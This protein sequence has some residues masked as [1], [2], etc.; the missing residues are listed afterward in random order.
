VATYY[1]PVP[2]NFPALRINLTGEGGSDQT[3]ICFREGSTG[4]FD[5][6]FDAHKLFGQ[7]GVP[8]VYSFASDEC[9]FSVNSYPSITDCGEVMIGFTADYPG[10]YNFTFTG[11]ETFPQGASILLEDLKEGVLIDCRNHSAYGFTYSEGEDPERFII[12]FTVISG[13]E[14]LTSEHLAIVP[15]G[16][17][18]HLMI[19]S[20]FREGELFIHDLTGRMVHRERVADTGL[21]VVAT[22]GSKGWYIVRVVSSTGVISQKVYIP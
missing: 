16:D 20:S 17:Q 7:Y 8:Q 5:A 9:K 12:H 10:T 13:H 22:P 14:E 18:L 15:S 19:P 3:T 1:L 21:S 6:D 11:M 4:G 2:S